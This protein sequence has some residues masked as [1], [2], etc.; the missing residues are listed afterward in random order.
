MSLAGKK[1]GLKTKR[2]FY[3]FN[4]SDMATRILYFLLSNN[5]LLSEH[6]KSFLPVCISRFWNCVGLP[7]KRARHTQSHPFKEA[8]Q[9]EGFGGEEWGFLKLIPRAG[10]F[11]QKILYKRRDPIWLLQKLLHH[12]KWHTKKKK[13]LIY[14]LHLSVRRPVFFF[15]FFYMRARHRSGRRIPLGHTI[16]LFYYFNKMLCA[17]GKLYF[18]CAA[19]D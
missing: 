18:W 19:G 3:D 5:W 16:S 14:I 10:I 11:Q 8:L 1:I 17:V 12:T 15:S 4:L 13:K 2:A 7:I 6:G 9:W